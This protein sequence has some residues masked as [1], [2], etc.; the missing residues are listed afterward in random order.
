MSPPHTGVTEYTWSMW[1]C[2][3]S[4]AAGLSRC[5]REHVAQ[6]LLDPDPRVDDQALLPRAGR[7]DVAVG[8]EGGSREGDGEHGW[9][10]AVRSCLDWAAVVAVMED[11]E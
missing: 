9:S 1:P 7:E 6:G 8:A 2:V 10:V 3:S 11:R 4:T 5:S